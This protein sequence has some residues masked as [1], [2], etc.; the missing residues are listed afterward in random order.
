MPFVIMNPLVLS[1]LRVLFLFS[2]FL[3]TDLKLPD[4]FINQPAFASRASTFT[5]FGFDLRTSN[6]LPLDRHLPDYRMPECTFVYTF[7]FAFAL[8]FTL[9]LNE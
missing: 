8:G 1:L 6:K 4:K 9:R 7:A 3:S 2:T 5:R